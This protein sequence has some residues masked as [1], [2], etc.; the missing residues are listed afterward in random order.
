MGRTVAPWRRPSSECASTRLQAPI[1]LD[2]TT[3]AELMGLFGRGHA[4]FNAST[5]QQA[6]ANREGCFC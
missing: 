4:E 5:P 2:A 3:H 6:R 1:A